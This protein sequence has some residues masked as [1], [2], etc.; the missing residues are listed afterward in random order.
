M[1]LS[2]AVSSTSSVNESPQG[3]LTSIS[4]PPQAFVTTVES[5]GTDFVALDICTEALLLCFPT[6]PTVSVLCGP[7]LV[8]TTTL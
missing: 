7:V 3:L 2:G 5:Q 8:Y 6:E 1:G 4:L